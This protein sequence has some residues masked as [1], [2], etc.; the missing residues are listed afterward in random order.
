MKDTPVVATPTLRRRPTDLS[1]DEHTC[2]RERLTGSCSEHGARDACFLREGSLK[3][4]ETQRES[5]RERFCT[6]HAFLPGEW[7]SL[8]CGACQR[9]RK[10]CPL[11]RLR[12][13]YHVVVPRSTLVGCTS[14]TLHVRT[15]PWST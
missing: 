15:P 6:I 7:T 12:S 2:A 3:S 5:E 4:S 10:P 8:T 11:V 13:E 14:R 1:N 9:L